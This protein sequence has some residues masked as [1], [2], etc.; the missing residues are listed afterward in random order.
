M[1]SAFFGHYLL[2]EGVVT[3]RQL[4]KTLELQDQVRLK[5]GVIAIN[6]GFLTAE[7]VEAIHGIQA[8][9]DR[10]FGEI[11]MTEGYLQEAQLVHLLKQQQSEHLLLSQS[12]IDQGILTLQEFEQHIEAYKHSYDMSEAEYL[13]LEEGDMSIVV[14]AFLAFEDEERGIYIDYVSLLLKNM[15]R[16]VDAHVSVDRIKKVNSI[17]L[18]HVLRQR[19]ITEDTKYLTALSGEEDVLI[20]IASAYVDEVITEMNEYAIDAIGEFLNL[21]NGLFLVNRSDSGEEMELTVQAYFEDMSIRSSHN[22]YIV[23]I[24]TTFGTLKL[25]VGKL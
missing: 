1:F 25:I 18:T 12:L 17:T 4:S 9:K 24:Y 20:Q 23:P 3:T 6:D 22:L 21:H 10:R 8:S 14:N 16:F 13:A 2:N 15:I 19:M 7:Q 5:L 11:A